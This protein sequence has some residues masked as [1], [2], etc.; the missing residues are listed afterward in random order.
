[1]GLIEDLGVYAHDCRL[2]E[3]DALHLHMDISEAYYDLMQL[4][5]EEFEWL[6]AE[7]WNDCRKAKEQKRLQLLAEYPQL[8]AANQ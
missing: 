3:N 1:M 5:K 8:D 7:C 6:H 2:I 4:T